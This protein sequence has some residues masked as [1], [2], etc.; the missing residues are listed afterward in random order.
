MMTEVPILLSKIFV[1]LSILVLVGIIVVD[2]LYYRIP[3]VLTLTLLALFPLLILSSGQY[4]A[5]TGIW[6]MIASFAICFALFAFNLIG[7]GDAKLIPVLCLWVG[8]TDVLFFLFWGTIL[9]GVVAITYMFAP[10]AIGYSSSTIRQLV[11]SATPLKA[12]MQKF[13]PDIEHI[14][15]EVLSLQDKRN[16]PYGIGICIAGIYMIC[17]QW[18]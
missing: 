12:V 5:I 10:R 6:V 13:V 18:T 9:G 3:N 14:E 15:G 7:G 2:F 16:M 1:H 8:T 4:Q 17:Q 11:L